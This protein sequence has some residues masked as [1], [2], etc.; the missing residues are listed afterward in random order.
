MKSNRDTADLK[1][2]F[3]YIIAL[4]LSNWIVKEKSLVIT[5]LDNLTFYSSIYCG[6]K[7]T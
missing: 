7:A 1:Q 6:F 5:A 2:R 3:L 4:T